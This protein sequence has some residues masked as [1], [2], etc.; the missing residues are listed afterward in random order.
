M[1]ITSIE[2]LTQSFSNDVTK[3]KQHIVDQNIETVVLK[4][5]TRIEANEFC[6]KIDQYVN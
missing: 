5:N 3:I 4:D 1:I 2:L 6:L